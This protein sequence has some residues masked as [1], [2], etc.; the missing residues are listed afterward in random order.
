MFLVSKK[1]IIGGALGNALEAYDYVVW[2][3]FSVY[4][5]NEFLPPQSQLSDI[6]FLFL[7]TYI[8]RPIGGIVGGILADQLGRK[9][10]LT[11]SIFIMGIC[12]L[13]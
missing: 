6:F 7:I 9:R 5:S 12:R 11:L 10:V 13:F 4:L 2:G 1:T 8:L 3:L